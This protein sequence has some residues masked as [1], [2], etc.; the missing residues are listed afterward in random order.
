MANLIIKPTS[1]GSLILQDEGGSAAISV[2]AAGTTTFAENATFSGTANVYGQGAFPAGHVIQVNAVE[3]DTTQ[4]DTTSNA[5]TSLTG[6][7]IPI[8]PLYSNSKIHGHFS[9][10]WGTSTFDMVV[11]FRIIRV[12]SGA[13]SVTLH[14]HGNSSGGAAT[15]RG[16]TQGLRAMHDANGGTHTNLNFFDAP[17][18]TALV[19]YTLQMYRTQSGTTYIN[20]TQSDNATYGR[21]STTMTCMEIKV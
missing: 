5:W 3:M 10:S 9:I 13:S 8:T 12:V 6:C 19:T 14:E 17:G 16:Q 4:A 21:G 18:T 15:F 20:R 7:N 1:G 11:N 2:A